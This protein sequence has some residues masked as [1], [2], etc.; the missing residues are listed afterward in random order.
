MHKG[1]LKAGAFFSAIAVILGAFAAHA[2]SSR[3][4]PDELA[5]F[6]TGVRY[7]MYH[8]FAIII[9]GILYKEFTQRETIWAGKAFIFGII[10]FS[11]TLYLLTYFKS[12]GNSGMFWLGAVT[13]IGGTLLIGGW[14]LLL[15]IFFR[16]KQG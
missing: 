16:K 15:R 13:P 2:L 4:L 8:A 9:T 6:E 7:Q 12:A 10:I 5:I 3:L 14:L 11:G 1:L